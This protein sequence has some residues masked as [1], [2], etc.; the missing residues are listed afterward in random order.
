M[1]V[2][3]ACLIK[4][5]TYKEAVM[6]SP[7]FWWTIIGIVLMICEFSVPGLILFFFGLGALV[8]ALA[9]WLFPLSLTW[10]L[11]LFTAASLVSLFGLRRLLKPVFTGRTSAVTPNALTEG[12]VDAEGVVRTAIS[13][14]APGKVT[15]N[16][17]DWKAESEETLSEG[18]SVVVVGQKSLTLIIKSK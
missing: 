13:P 10:Q 11:A 12:L 6:L 15:V 17:T 7:A 8:T 5:V 1:P 16:G 18:Q 3:K 2:K 9:A 14:G 4:G